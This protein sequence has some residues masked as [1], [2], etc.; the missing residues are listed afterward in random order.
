VTGVRRRDS[1]PAAL[2]EGIRRR[3]PAA[4][5]RAISLIESTAPAD[6][7]QAAELLTALGG[8]RAAFLLGVSGVPGVGKSTFID[9]LG[10][11]LLER[12]STVAVLAVDPS[13]TVSGGSILGDKTRMQRL[14]VDHRAFVRPSPTAGT[15]GGVAPRTPEAIAL[16]EAA[17]FD[18]IIIET[19]GVGQSET[20]A[21]DLADVFL[22]LMLPGG[23]DELQGI[24]R[25]LMERAD[26]IAVNKADGPN[27]ERATVT[28][29]DYRTAM[30]LMRGR[31]AAGA[32]PVLTCSA[33]EGRG[34]DEIW[35]A[36]V[37][38]R[39]MLQESGELAARRRQQRVRLL[40]AQVEQ[41]LRAGL[42]DNAE[43]RPLVAEVTSAVA[44]GQL[45]PSVGAE[46]LLSAVRVVPKG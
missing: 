5:G 6:R 35:N 38:R 46:R 2:I 23:G 29:R 16:C 42:E 30:Q 21:A 22:V 17:G 28:A 25:G 31:D 44:S 32:P 33:L 24:K 45:P 14:A 26:V 19:V 18:V 3:D 34:L 11:R 12:G 43:V 9:A 15:L 20:A 13:S 1:A 36:L 7:A 27:A 37:E 8:T 39:V 10:T 4:L 40:W 41:R